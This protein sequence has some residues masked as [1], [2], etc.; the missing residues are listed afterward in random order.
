MHKTLYINILAKNRWDHN[1]DTGKMTKR[2]GSKWGKNP[3]TRKNMRFRKDGSN[4][5]IASLSRESCTVILGIT[6]QGSV[7]SSNVQ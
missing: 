4:R 3:L 5:G 7:R 6:L 2:S 1:A